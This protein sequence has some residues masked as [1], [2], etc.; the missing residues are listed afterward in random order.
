MNRVRD[1]DE[2]NKKCA[3]ELGVHRGAGIEVNIVVR[4]AIGDIFC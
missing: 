3:K 1:K 2:I 4:Y